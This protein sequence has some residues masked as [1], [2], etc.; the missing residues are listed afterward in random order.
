MQLVEQQLHTLTRHP[1]STH[2][3]RFSGIHVPQSSFLRSILYIVVCPFSFGRCFVCHS[4]IYGFWWHHCIGSYAYSWRSKMV[5]E[6]FECIFTTLLYKRGL[7]VPFLEV[8]NIIL[9][10]VRYRFS[11]KHERWDECWSQMCIL[12]INL[13]IVYHI[14]LKET[15][16]V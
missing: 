4:S 6:R 14:K 16:T 10:R 3:P 5:A 11:S 8:Y 9:Y 12:A 1:S 7:F 15:Q 13:K 2:S